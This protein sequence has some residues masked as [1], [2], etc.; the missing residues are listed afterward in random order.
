MPVL[1]LALVRPQLLRSM[2]DAG[3]GSHANLQTILTLGL[4]SITITV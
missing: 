2:P 4:I 1:G 3:A